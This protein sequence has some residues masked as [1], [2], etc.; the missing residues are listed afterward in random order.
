MVAGRAA[1]DSALVHGARNNYHKNRKAMRASDRRWFNFMFRFELALCLLAGLLF[2]PAKSA[3]EEGGSSAVPTV[4]GDAGPCSVDL[5]VVDAAGNPVYGATIEARISFGF[6][7]M[8]KLEVEVGTNQQGQARVTGLPDSE[9]DSFYFE[10]SKGDARGLAFYNP[11][12]S[13]EAR[14]FLVLHQR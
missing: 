2:F 8:R 9:S 3:A 5:V 7:G 6:L 11:G 4:D 14:H 10:G 12:A 13:C 1:R